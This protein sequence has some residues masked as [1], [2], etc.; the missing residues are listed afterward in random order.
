MSYGY[1]Y[2]GN[3]L[4][5]WHAKLGNFNTLYLSWGPSK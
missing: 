4:E 5:S 2:Y 1:R 3:A